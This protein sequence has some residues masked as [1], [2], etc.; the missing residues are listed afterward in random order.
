[1]RLLLDSQSLLWY[2]DQHQLLSRPAHAAITD[3]QNDLLLSAA[4]LWEISIKVGLGKLTISS[5]FQ[6]W[7]EKAISDL[8]LSLLPITVEYADAQA[9][10]PNHHRDPFDRM[11]I[12]QSIVE[13]IPIVTN[14]AIFARYGVMSVW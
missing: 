4:S 6:A 7:M 9:K 1:M 3:P 14:D 13:N 12:A 10:L 2:V 5:P 8:D 11:L